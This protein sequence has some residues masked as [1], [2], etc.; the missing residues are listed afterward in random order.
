MTFGLGKRKVLLLNKNQK[1]DKTI[2]LD[3]KYS[4]TNKINKNLNKMISEVR[5]EKLEY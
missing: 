4:E 2:R 3:I 1:E 5:G